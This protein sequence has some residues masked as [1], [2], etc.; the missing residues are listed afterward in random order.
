[1]GCYCANAGEKP[2]QKVEADTMKRKG[3]TL[4]ELLI[5]VAIIAILAA[6]AVPNF[7]EAQ[8]RSRV[9]RVNADMRSMVTAIEAYRVDTNKYPPHRDLP[10]DLQVLTTPVAYI[11]SLPEDPFWPYTPG[12]TAWASG[13]SFTWQDLPDIYYHMWATWGGDDNLR[14]LVEQGRLYLLNSYGPDMDD[15]SPWDLTAVYDATNGTKS[16]GDIHRIGP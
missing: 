5:V 2:R 3:F 13:R 10:S 9:A 6:I 8:M 1:M 16:N 12:P 14:R 7:L 11:T 15:D 4:I